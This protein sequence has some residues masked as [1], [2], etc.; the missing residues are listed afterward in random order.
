MFAAS[1]NVRNF[2]EI[3]LQKM[4][5]ATPEILSFW[6]N[7]VFTK[8]VNKLLFNVNSYRQMHFN[9]GEDKIIRKLPNEHFYNYRKCRW[10]VNGA[11]I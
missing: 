5:G 1:N 10:F 7:E 8:L 4:S 9:P 2:D 11:D 3:S 6:M